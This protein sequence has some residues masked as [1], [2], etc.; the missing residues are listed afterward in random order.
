MIILIYQLIYFSLYL[1][2]TEEGRQVEGVYVH[3]RPG[4]IL[5]MSTP[6]V[7]PPLVDSLSSSTLLH[8]GVNGVGLHNLHNYQTN[9]KDSGEVSSPGLSNSTAEMM[10]SPWSTV[11]VMNA[12][13]SSYMLSNLSANTEYEVFLEPFSDTETGQPT[14]LLTNQT[15]ENGEWLVV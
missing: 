11:T 9:S 8:S 13:A 5:H 7:A 6:S 14:A 1:Q 3:Y 2:V 15:L 12:F 4:R 10:L